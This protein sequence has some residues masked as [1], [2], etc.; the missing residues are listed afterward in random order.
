MP[1]H[2]RFF[3]N[4]LG[5]RTVLVL[6]LVATMMPAAIFAFF[7]MRATNEDTRAIYEGVLLEQ[8]ARDS[9]EL[10]DNLLDIQSS[11]LVLARASTILL[12]GN[13]EDALSAYLRIDDRITTL[14]ALDAEG[15][16][17]CT[18]GADPASLPAGVG[19]TD[20]PLYSII[21]RGDATGL[22]L[23]VPQSGG[24]SGHYVAIVA[25]TKLATMIRR[26]EA[27]AWTFVALVDGDDRLVA[28][29]GD[30]DAIARW[31]DGGTLDQGRVTAFGTIF[32][33]RESE[34][35][36]DVL[37]RVP[38]L[39]DQFWM[40]VELPSEAAYRG[41]DFKFVATS[42]LPF[43]MILVG[44]LCAYLAADRLIVR[45]VVYLARIARAYGRG[46]LNLRASIVE[47]EAPRELADLSVDFAEM[48][49]R[50]G[51]RETALRAS[52]DEN[53]ALLFEVY[54]RVKNNLQM[55]ISLINMEMRDVRNERDAE[56]LAQVRM[57][58]YGLS[59]AHEGM[60][61]SQFTEIVQVDDLIRDL[62]DHLDIRHGG[63]GS[64]INISLD[65]IL[66]PAEM[67]VPFGMLATEAL[68]VAGLGKDAGRESVVRL[69]I[70][71]SAN[72]SGGFTFSIML[73]G[74]GWDVE[75][76]RGQF[77]LR[78]I[79]GYSRQLRGTVEIGTVP[80]G[81]HLTLTVPPPRETKE[82][83]GIAASRRALSAGQS[84]I[85]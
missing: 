34:G 15:R 61:R 64:V 48:A 81:G 27:S 63:S 17:T 1:G 49:R 47:R 65:P 72:P 79:Q 51:E 75:T 83:P 71:L 58:I 5:I 20:E 70:S 33:R 8:A 78:L 38:M 32:E 74:D 9:L 40:I 29:D 73:G 43:A 54:H 50:L 37:L 41:L 21:D 67:A 12:G 26:N 28:A 42:L 4:R 36:G 16:V 45:N 3:M 57:R 6:V 18:S 25:D 2:D 44:V 80:D 19:L 59:L 55:M 69:G 10:R 14:F 24:K 76:P 22:A 66:I 23:S 39:Q 62:L 7:Q 35:T 31:R 53:R 13:C 46:K 52:L 84:A 11:V 30:A 60:Q 82:R 85:R 56:A 68:A 77:S